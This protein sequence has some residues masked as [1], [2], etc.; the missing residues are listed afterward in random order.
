[1]RVSVW[2][3][4][5]IA[6]TTDERAIKRAY[7]A[8]LRI[9]SP[10][11]DPAGYM[12]LREAY[13][14]AKRFAEYAREPRVLEPADAPEAFEPAAVEV[15]QPDPPSPQRQALD[16]L[17]QL[18]SEGQLDAF[19]KKM[20]DVRDA[21]IF[22]TLD[23]QQ[24][25]VGEIAVMVHD[26]EVQDLEW[27]GGLA[28]HLGAREHENIFEPD[29]EY[30]HAYAELLNAYQAT[31]QMA[32]RTRVQSAD[33]ITTTPGYLHVYHVLTS[34]FDSERMIALTRSQTY[35]RLVEALLERA[36]KD[37]S[38]EIPP[39]NR[40]WWER[41]AM[42]GLHR[43]MVEPA[44]VATPVENRDSSS[45]PI[46]IIWP[47]VVL[48]LG[49]FRTCSFDSGPGSSHTYGSSTADYNS[50]RMREI[51]ELASGKMPN[52]PPTR[53]E[54]LLVRDSPL[55]SFANCDA[56]TRIDLMAQIERIPIATPKAESEYPTVTLPWKLVLDESKPEVAA[57]LA[58]CTPPPA[59]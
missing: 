43:P 37:T 14:A 55:P 25:F 32:V 58:K 3:V 2:E 13:E 22:T 26:S 59:K 36:R 29:S 57:L 54:L 34:P 45:F 4:L 35:H 40:Q 18:L 20:D 21:G 6:E 8:K 15:R 10:E 42:A 56:Q 5:G 50:S 27:C 31:R 11:S 52:G 24:D 19:V 1:M 9:H 53:T 46:W 38:L 23:E 30:W 48:I 17:R 51:R 49:S 28:S 33:E 12:T 41:T 16:E 39:E 44:P 7:A 47:I